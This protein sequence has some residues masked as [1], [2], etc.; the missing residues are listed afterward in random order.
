MQPPPAD[1]SGT[2]AFCKNLMASSVPRPV[3]RKER[4]HGWDRLEKV[5]HRMYAWRVIVFNSSQGCL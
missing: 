3:K 4:F 1:N 2:N 5:C